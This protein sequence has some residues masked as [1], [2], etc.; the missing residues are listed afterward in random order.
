VNPVVRFFATLGPAGYV[1]IAPATAGSALVA[2]IGWFLPVPP[3]AV[4]LA[5]LVVGTALA[6]WLAGEAEKEL[7]HDAKPIVCDE[8]VGQTI[9]LLY[10][11][12]SLA[13]FAFSFFLFRVFDVWKPLGA[14][15]AQ[16][17]PGGQGI[18]ADDVIAGLTSCAV[19]HLVTVGSIRF[20]AWDPWAWAAT[21]LPF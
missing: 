12:H 11:P 7:G 10:V 3:I 5:L 9:A 21:I 20:F 8:A 2:A 14:R 18:V 6:V 13:A 4:T 1:P 16:A 17:L 19:F 15:E